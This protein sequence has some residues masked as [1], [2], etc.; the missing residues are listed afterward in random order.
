MKKTVLYEDVIL[1]VPS[2]DQGESGTLVI[3]QDAIGNHTVGLAAGNYGDIRIALQPGKVS[4]LTW[5]RDDDGVY[6]DSFIGT[7]DVTISPPD[8][9]VDLQALLVDTANAKLQWTVPSGEPGTNKSPDLFYLI[10]EENEIPSGAPIN[11]YNMLRLSTEPGA[12]GSTQQYI[13]TG[14]ESGK[15]YYL[16]IVSE[17]TTFGTARRSLISNVVTFV[18]SALDSSVDLVPKRI[19]IRENSVY[20]AILRTW[21]AP[22]ELFTNPKPIS[23]LEKQDYLIDNN[24]VPEGLP[25]LNNLPISAVDMWGLQDPSWYNLPE[26]MFIMT[27]R[28]DGLYKLNYVY[29]LLD[30]DNNQG[31]LKLWG[32]GDGV[33]KFLLWERATTPLVWATSDAWS[34]GKAT[35]NEAFTNDIQFLHVGFERKDQVFNGIVPY[36]VRNTKYN[37]TGSKFKRNVPI[38]TFNDSMGTNLFLEEND[39]DKVGIIAKINRFYN[40]FDWILSNPFRSYGAMQ[41]STPDDIVLSFKT[42]H[43]WDFDQKLN[44]FKSNGSSIMFNLKEAAPYMQP[45]N[46]TGPTDRTRIKNI[47]PKLDRNDIAVTTD[48]QS[49]SHVARICYLIVARYGSNSSIPSSYNSQYQENDGLYGLNL[50]DF[51][52]YENEIEANWIQYDGYYNPH[53]FAAMMSAVYDGHKGALGIGFGVKQADPN[54]KVGNAGLVSPNLD[55][56]KEMMSWWDTYRGIGDYPFDFYSVHHYNAFRNEPYTPV[57]SSVPAYGLPPEQGDI[58]PLM[59]NMSDFRDKFTPNLEIAITET[60]YD[61]QNGGMHSPQDSTQ[62][63]RSRHKAVWLMRNFMLLASTGTDQIQQYWWANRWPTRLEDLNPANIQRELFYTSG[64]TDGILDY[65]DTNRKPLMSWWYVTAFRNELAGYKFS[66]MIAEK[67]MI[68]TEEGNNIINFH[69]DIYA[70]AFTN[71]DNTDG[72][73]AIWLG[74]S[75]WSNTNAQVRVGNAQLNVDVISFEGIETKYPNWDVPSINGNT[76][77]LIPLA[78]GVSKYVTVNVS[79]YPILIKTNNIGTKKLITPENVAVQTLSG[80]SIK[81]VWVDRNIGNNNTLI[82][83][84]TSATNGFV[85]INNSYIDTG[86]YIATGL[87]PNT[88]YYFRVGFSMD[89]STSDL[90]VVVGTSTDPIIPVPTNLREVTKT[91]STITLGW[92]YANESEIDRF[93]IYR[94]STLNGEYVSVGTVNAS[95]REFRNVGLSASTTYYYKLRAA[96]ELVVSQFTNAQVTTTNAPST[97][98]PVPESSATNGS[99]DIIE[100][101]FDEEMKDAESAINA[102][103]IVE[104]TQYGFSVAHNVDEISIDSADRTKVLLRIYSNIL[105]GSTITVSYDDSLGQLKSLY[106]HLVET[107]SDMLV[108]DNITIAYRPVVSWGAINGSLTTFNNNVTVNTQD[109]MAVS[110][111]YLPAGQSGI[112]KLNT[113]SG[114]GNGNIIALSPNKDAIEGINTTY[115]NTN[116][117]Q[118]VV[119]AV[120]KRN[121]G[122]SELIP[123]EEQVQIRLNADGSTVKYEYS[124]NGGTTWNVIREEPQDN[125][126]LWLKIHGMDPGSNFIEIVASGLSVLKIKAD[127]PILVGNDIDDTLEAS[128]SQSTNIL[129]EINNSGNWLNYVGVIDVGNVDLPAGYYKFKIGETDVFSESDIALSPAFTEDTQELVLTDMLFTQLTQSIYNPANKTYT[130]T[131]TTSANDSYGWD[132]GLQL[133]ISTDGGFYFDTDSVGCWMGFSTINGSVNYWST[134]IGVR[135]SEF[136]YITIFDDGIQREDVAEVI[137]EYHYRI[138]GRY[139]GSTKQFRLERSNNNWI[140]YQVVYTFTANI[141]ETVYPY[142]NMKGEPTSKLVNPQHEGLIGV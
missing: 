130:S 78:D 106:N 58:I 9:I 38:R 10:L 87:D 31:N 132:T 44:L 59:K 46:Y 77:S 113:R 36:G 29:L 116:K 103:T 30:N 60:G 88:T 141:T 91:S 17:R 15:R 121:Y 83:R 75:N 96:K 79:E 50:I 110:N 80:N 98:P 134:P 33:N 128:S 107:F 129:Y 52:E 122:S 19:P 85:L 105:K 127:P 133:P 48:P 84:S 81:L 34:W 6:W 65:N 22:G 1:G 137:P 40:P 42:S 111:Y 11:N 104:V 8:P 74:V 62:F 45:T 25:D 16:A 82:Y 108:T 57:W 26:D 64:Y 20:G 126:E 123:L 12:I 76:T 51:F 32:S 28:L 53:E 3:E 47:N 41:D 63:L 67:G 23:N 115:F 99:G 13:L 112:V 43:M 138:K 49:Y 139:D 24:G 2:S 114:N 73:I 100:L 109:T 27:I 70:A 97:V 39:S 54:M 89:D 94:S 71:S 55:F 119:G 131:S 124:I 101:I 14:L 5:Y 69:P 136:N 135:I 117:F 93:I 35:L 37:I 142:F 125:I 102:F 21:F 118:G 90:S 7:P 18:T 4:V 92:D 86:E 56:I 95:Q 72:I 140:S 61:E 66:H 120:Y 68:L